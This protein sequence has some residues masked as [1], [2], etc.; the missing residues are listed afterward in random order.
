RCALAARLRAGAPAAGR[1]R[2]ADHDPG[3]RPP[4]VAPAGHRA[5]S[6]GGGGDGVSSFHF[7]RCHH[8]RKRIIQY[9]AASRSYYALSGMLDAPP[10]R[11][12][13]SLAY[14]GG[15]LVI[16]LRC[17]SAATVDVPIGPCSS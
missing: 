12:M 15:T 14:G 13:T 2:G 9:A 7:S 1:G 16:G 5:D 11:G 8:P 4:P 17:A 3:R 6:R 10:S